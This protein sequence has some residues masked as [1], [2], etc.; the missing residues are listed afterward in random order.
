MCCESSDPGVHCGGGRYAGVA[1]VVEGQLYL[2]SVRCLPTGG[3]LA[4]LHLVRL[5]EAKGETAL[6]E[7]EGQALFEAC[8]TA[9]ETDGSKQVPCCSHLC[10]ANNGS[11]QVF[12]LSVLGY[13]RPYQYSRAWHFS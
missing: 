2:P 7:V 10:G 4:A 12:P 13:A 1:L 8:S 3:R 11:T 5:L 6:T 9:E